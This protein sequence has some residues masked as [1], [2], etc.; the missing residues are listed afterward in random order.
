MLS[1]SGRACTAAFRRADITARISA[2][3]GRRIR[4]FSLHTRP[5]FNRALWI[6]AGSA[7]LSLLALSRNWIAEDEHE[8]KTNLEPSVTTT[9]CIDTHQPTSQNLYMGI[10]KYLKHEIVLLSAVVIITGMISY[11]NIMTPLII[12]K[13][14]TVVQSM[15]KTSPVSFAKLNNTAYQLLIIFLMNGFLTFLDIAAVAR[16]GENLAHRM[17]IDLYSSIL[18]MDISFFDTHMHGELLERLAQ[19]QEFKHTFKMVVTQGLKCFTQVVGSALSLL[20]ISVP[21]TLRLLLTMPAIYIFMN[22][23]GSY[24]RRLSRQTSLSESNSIGIAGEC[25]SNIRTVRSFAAEDLEI[26]R[27]LKSIS[28]S[29]QLA[30]NLGFH[31]GQVL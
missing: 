14:I 21:M 7:S 5:P 30:T 4:P 24:L 3:F 15:L 12:G 17:R 1:L 20:C 28:E 6:G 2:T 8:E 31:I 26:K 25:V 22:I 11:I 23:Y 18:S 27:Y 16:L 19:V 10:W 13:L 9:C 29:S